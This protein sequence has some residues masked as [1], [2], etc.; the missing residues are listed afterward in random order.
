MSV[1]YHSHY[2][3][4][5]EAARTEAL[6]EFGITYREI[7]ESGVY[8]PVIEATVKYRKPA[9]YDDL[10]EIKVSIPEAPDFR[11]GIDYE[12]YREEGKR[13]G[14]L[15]ATGRVELCFFD[16]ENERLTRAPEKLKGALRRAQET[17]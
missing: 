14:E 1:V 12:V 15:V 11:I 5:F 6:R 8:M 17:S 10:L 2:I 3:D 7:E 13:R 9:Y 16:R 4:Y